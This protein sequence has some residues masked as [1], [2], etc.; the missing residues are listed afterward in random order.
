MIWHYVGLVNACMTVFLFSIL[1]DCLH[2][3]Q[4][5][6]EEEKKD[7]RFGTWNTGDVSVGVGGGGRGGG[8]MRM[9]CAVDTCIG[10]LNLISDVLL[11]RY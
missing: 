2:R 7:V 1:Q 11:V 4:H 3:V 8:S 10:S 5:C 9:S 6:L